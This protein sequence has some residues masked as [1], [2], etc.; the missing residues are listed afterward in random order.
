MIPYEAF[1]P[2]NAPQQSR[3][4][5][6]SY[7]LPIVCFLASLLLIP[8]PVPDRAYFAIILTVVGGV[9]WFVIWHR[10][11]LQMRREA[12]L[13]KI[14]GRLT[15]VPRATV[16]H[17]KPAQRRRNMHL[18]LPRRPQGRRIEGNYIFENDYTTVP[19]V[20]DFGIP[21]SKEEAAVFVA[22]CKEIIQRPGIHQANVMVRNNELVWYLQ[23][24]SV[25][26]DRIQ[27]I[28]SS[29]PVHAAN[30]AS[31]QDLSVPLPRH[32]ARVDWEI[33]QIDDQSPWATTLQCLSTGSGVGEAV[34]IFA[35][36][37][38]QYPQRCVILKFFHLI[39]NPQWAVLITLENDDPT[40]LTTDAINTSVQLAQLGIRTRTV[41]GDASAVLGCLDPARS[42]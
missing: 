3:E 39:S 29:M 25:T 9:S 36:A 34:R 12:E 1:E 15:L 17:L 11:V 19:V 33:V 18:T 37:Q 38:R 42:V 31:I 4:E 23:F 5:K 10:H 27:S 30:S 16:T 40:I 32:P 6:P 22:L 41:C 35:L 14:L 20:A 24:H 2:N 8:L 13:D 26:Q 21:K 7:L 28:I